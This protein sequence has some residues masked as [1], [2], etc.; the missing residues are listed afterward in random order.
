MAPQTDWSPPNGADSKGNLLQNALIIQVSQKITPSKT[1]M[2]MEKTP[3]F[4]GWGGWG[5]TSSNG[6]F[7]IVIL[8]FQGCRLG[9]PFC[10]ESIGSTS[11]KNNLKYLETT[12]FNPVKTLQFHL[13][14][15]FCPRNF[16]SEKTGL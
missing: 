7:S 3:F 4:W 13:E 8:V 5:G 6:C 2:T 12:S 10:P 9:S 14:I 16:P 15:L 11:K 1:N